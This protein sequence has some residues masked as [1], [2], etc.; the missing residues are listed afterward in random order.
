MAKYKYYWQSN[1]KLPRKFSGTMYYY[2]RKKTRQEQ[3][4]QLWIDFVQWFI[5][6]PQQNIMLGYGWYK[7]M[8]QKFQ[9]RNRETC[10]CD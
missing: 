9:N 5:S 3:R 2:D 4:T 8:K 1:T 10:C 7:T 6:I